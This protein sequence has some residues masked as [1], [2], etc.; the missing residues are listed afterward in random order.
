MPRLRNM[1]LRPSSTSRTH[2]PGGPASHSTPSGARQTRTRQEP[3]GRQTR[4]GSLSGAHGDRETLARKRWGLAP[5]RARAL[6]T[7]PP[8]LGHGRLRP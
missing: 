2:L 7:G 1:N 5:G 3:Q 4:I 6:A 8:E